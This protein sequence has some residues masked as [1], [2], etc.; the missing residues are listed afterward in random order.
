MTGELLEHHDPRFRF[1]TIGSASLETLHEGCRWAEGPVWFAD[2]GCLIWSDIPN[3]RL[4]RWLPEHG[5]GV[6]RAPCGNI[7]GNSRDR[8]GRLVSCEHLGRRVIR[9]EP[10]GSLTVLADA[11]R[12][13]RLNSPNDLVVKSDGSIWFTDPTYGILSDYE[14]RKAEPEQDRRNLFRIDPADG[15]IASM[16]DDFVQPNGLAFSPDEGLLYVAD[17]G[18]SHDPDGPHHIRVFQVGA[19][20]RLSGGAVFAEVSPGVPDGLRLDSE[21][22]LW[23]SARDGVQCFAPD[24][25]LLGK[26]RLPRTV[27]NLAF[28]G[29]KRNRLFIT[30]TTAL[31]SIFVAATGL[32]R[33]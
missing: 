5:V 2:A 19:D 11:Y 33:P 3:D 16:A 28:G 12:G 27:S 25:T 30:A 1:L 23:V 13:C 24:G 15:S 22:N 26:I 20:N 31:Y 4:L 10:D 18:F 21:G 9:T 14:G 8:E 29:P 32:Q 17:S 7:N 6:F